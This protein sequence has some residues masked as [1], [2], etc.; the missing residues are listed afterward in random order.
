MQCPTVQPCASVITAAKSFG[1]ALRAS[2]IAARIA[3]LRRRPLRGEPPDACGGEVGAP[4][5]L[6]MTGLNGNPT[7]VE[8]EVATVTKLETPATQAERRE[9]LRDAGTSTFLD[10]VEPSP[11]GRFAELARRDGEAKPS[12][13][14][15]MP[16]ANYPVAADWTSNGAGVGVEPPLGQNINDM[17]P[18]GEAF[19]VEKSLAEGGSDERVFTPAP[20]VRDPS[21]NPHIPN[22]ARR[23]VT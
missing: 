2:A 5:K 10:H 7:M 8:R 21:A 3:E 6:A 12:L 22:I 9:V 18:V 19:E 14:G 20:V 11:V 13:I 16:S 17:E 4:W 23:K 1:R 15:T